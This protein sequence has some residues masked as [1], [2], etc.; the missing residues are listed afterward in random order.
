MYIYM[1]LH[2]DDWDGD[3]GDIHQDGELRAANHQP[4]YS[5]PR[6]GLYNM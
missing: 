6:D 2:D 5:P 1:Y 3:L 4:I